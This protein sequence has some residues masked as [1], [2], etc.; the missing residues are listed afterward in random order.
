MC[1]FEKLSRVLWYCEDLIVWE[2]KY[3]CR[4]ITGEVRKEVFEC[5]NLFNA[6]LKCQIVELNVQACSLF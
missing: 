2:P 4:I 6:R 1:G 3:R 5:L